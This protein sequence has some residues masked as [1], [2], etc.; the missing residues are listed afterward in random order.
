MYWF[1]EMKTRCAVLHKTWGL[2]FL[3][4][5]LLLPAD[6]SVPLPVFQPSKVL[7][8]SVSNHLLYPVGIAKD[9]VW[10]FSL[11]MSPQVTTH[12]LNIR[13]VG[14]TICQSF[15]FWGEGSGGLGKKSILVH[16]QTGFSLQMSYFVYFSNFRSVTD[17]TIL[18]LSFCYH[19]CC[20]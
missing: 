1:V 18:A 20:P 13:R 17:R 8:S 2:S 10:L 6:W 14:R 19:Y 15:M 11:E 7:V 5:D 4:M 9:V 3:G 16:L 12:M